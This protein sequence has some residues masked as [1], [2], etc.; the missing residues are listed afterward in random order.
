MNEC[1]VENGGVTLSLYVEEVQY[2][3]VFLF[4][5]EGPVQSLTVYLGWHS[6][7]CFF[8]GEV[9]FFGKWEEEEEEHFW[10]EDNRP[11]RRDE[12]A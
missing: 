5:M 10:Y 8:R 11:P 1:L 7:W 3:T 2:R 12:L 4:M 6:R 9:I